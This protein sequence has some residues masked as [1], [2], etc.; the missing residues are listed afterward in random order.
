MKLMR[1]IVLSIVSVMLFT[2]CGS[3]A[4]K[5]DGAPQNTAV[6]TTATPALTEKPELKTVPW[7]QDSFTVLLPECPF[8]A[9]TQ[10]TPGDDLCLVLVEQIEESEAVLYMDKLAEKG[11]TSS[12]ADADLHTAGLNYSNDSGVTVNVVYSSGMMTLMIQK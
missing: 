4:G 2:S 11:F 1:I 12:G 6:G 9:V 8:G 10:I 7:G 3:D 5:E